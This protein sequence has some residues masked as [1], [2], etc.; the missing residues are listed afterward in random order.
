MMIK[1][2]I[3]ICLLA[4]AGSAEA[5][6]LTKSPTANADVTSGRGDNDGLE[7]SPANVYVDDS[8]FAQSVN[9]GTTGNNGTCA[10]ANNDAHRFT[11]FDFSAIPTCT[12][13]A[14]I[15]SVTIRQLARVDATTG[16]PFTCA[17]ASWDN[18]SNFENYA[19]VDPVAVTNTVS[20]Q[21]VT[22]LVPSGHSWTAT[23]LQSGNLL[24][25]VVYSADTNTQRDF[26][27]DLVEVVVDYT[28]VA[29]PTPT[30]TVTP[31]PTLTSTPTPTPTPTVT[32]TKTLTPT[33]TITATL[34][35]TPTPTRTP[36][37]THTGPTPTI[38]ATPGVFSC[39]PE[40]TYQKVTL[41]H[42]TGDNAWPE[43]HAPPTEPQK[44]FGGSNNGNYCGA[45]NSACPGGICQLESSYADLTGLDCVNFASDLH[46]NDDYMLA[47]QVFLSAPLC[48]GGANNGAHCNNVVAS[49]CPGG[50]C[51]IQPGSGA[52]SNW[53][54]GPMVFRF[55]TTTAVPIG[56]RVQT[57][58]LAYAV[59]NTDSFDTPAR[60]FVITYWTSAPTSWTCSNIDWQRNLPP[61][62]PIAGTIPVLSIDTFAWNTMILANARTYFTPGAKTT[63]RAWVDGA[64]PFAANGVDMVTNNTNPDS[65]YGAPLGFPYLELCT[66]PVTEEHSLMVHED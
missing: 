26:V 48:V 20:F 24:V 46:L 8:N 28:V 49:I 35:V 66:V 3:I 43:R 25:E 62:E 4:F 14:T 31:T 33:P 21:T 27:I 10:N 13:C 30:K 61:G 44:C 51:V 9:T 65:D 53:F 16:T 55:D 22:E 32:A 52:W 12:G 47:H 34:T 58:R 18:G 39:A 56:R 36:T 63:F 38:A 29:T 17:R 7:I 23:E 60:N 45:A 54:A 57:A 64:E 1:G 37:P 40:A 15:N 6:T 11:G 2:I 19:A 59:T 50:T 42:A 5:A 41:T